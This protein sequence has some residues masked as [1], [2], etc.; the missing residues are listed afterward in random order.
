MW[1][2]PPWGVRTHTSSNSMNYTP[3]LEKSRNNYD[4]F[5]TSSSRRRQAEPPTRG[6][7][8]IVRRLPPHR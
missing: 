8:Q 7:C 6:M 4:S 3:S 1:F 5:S 2:R